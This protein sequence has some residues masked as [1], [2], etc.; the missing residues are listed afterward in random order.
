LVPDFQRFQFEQ[1]RALHDYLTVTAQRQRE[2][3]AERRNEG[4]LEL[5]R[6]RLLR[7]LRAMDVERALIS[8]VLEP[9]TRGLDQRVLE[10]V[11]GAP[12]PTRELRVLEMY[13]TVFRDWGW[14]DPENDRALDVLERLV[15]AARCALGQPL[16]LGKL[17]VF[18]AGACRLAADV[19]RTLGPSV[20]V[21]LDINPLP[22]LIGERLLRGGVVDLY[23]YPVG[24][25][26]IANMAVLQ[27]L[28]CRLPPRQGLVLALADTR[29][30]P[31]AADSLDSVLT[32]WYIDVV[33]AE[34]VDTAATIHRV[35]RSGGMW[36]NQGP[37]RFT[38]P[39]AR[40]YCIEEVHELVQ[41]SG[42]ELVATLSE[43]IPYF[44]SPH[45][46]SRRIETVYGFAARKSGPAPVVPER[47]KPEPAWLRD[48]S[49][50]I[51]FS[52]ELHDLEVRFV[53]SAGAVSLIDGAR[54]VKDLAEALGG[55][56]QLD[57]AQL[58]EPIRSFLGS[59]LPGRRASR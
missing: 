26:G 29:E 21:A 50:P 35:L 4:L 37:L 6:E 43:D 9:L 30:P 47:A 36:F 49:E 57:P 51:P 12:Y 22:L 31:F 23:E 2:I 56:L 53:F 3:G 46:G 19:H 15:A 28:H 25:R 7:L 17:A 42:F 24:A 52:P 39:A 59:V 27:Q 11:P 45:A 20:T 32:P 55:E 5:T 41:K 38:G 58:I 44:D 10:A 48:V 18:G 34:L 13:E 40:L 14:G 33:E 1:R 54:S 8:D 16:E